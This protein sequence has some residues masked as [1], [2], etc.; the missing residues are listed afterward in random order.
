MG[1]ENIPFCLFSEQ[2]DETWLK[3]FASKIST[4]WDFTA[5]HVNKNSLNGVKR[6][7]VSD[8]VCFRKNPCCNR[9]RRVFSGPLLEDLWQAYLG[10]RTCLRQWCIQPLFFL[11]RKILN[12]G[13]RPQYVHALHESTTDQSV[14]PSGCG[15]F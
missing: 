8:V 12:T 5:I 1:N 2:A 3:E 6:D 11:V 7:I 13:N 14:H 9:H 10:D 4:P 15:L